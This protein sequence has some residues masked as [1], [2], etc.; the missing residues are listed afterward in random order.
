MAPISSLLTVAALATTTGVTS[1]FSV[2][3]TSSSSTTTRPLVSSTTKL[4]ENFGFDFAE[5][6]VENTPQLILGEANYKKW[7]NSVDPNNMLNRQVRLGFWAGVPPCIVCFV[8][9]APPPVLCAYGF[10]SVSG[11]YGIIGQTQTKGNV[12]NRLAHTSFNHR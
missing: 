12:D 9:R 3:S 5:D 11:Q 4:Y 7:V 2:G 6:Q 1:A 10:V 8:L